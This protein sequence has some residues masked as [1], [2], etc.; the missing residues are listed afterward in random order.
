MKK[1]LQYLERKLARH[2]V[3]HVTILIALGQAAV[4]AMLMTRPQLSLRLA[5]VPDLVMVGE[6]Y[7]LFSF[8]ILPPGDGI[9]TLFGIYLFYFMGESLEAQWGTVRYNLY[10]L[11]AY[12]ATIAVAWINP[13]DPTLSTFIGGSVFLA[14]AWLFPDFQLMLF[15][16]LPV[17]IRYLALLTWL[18]FGWTMIFGQWSERLAVL[19]SVLNFLLFFGNDIF[20]RIRSN[21]RKMEQGFAQLRQRNTPLHRCTVCGVTERDDRSLEFRFCSKC[22]GA[23]EYCE[24][25]LKNHE[26]KSGSPGAKTG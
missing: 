25:H 3:P 17:K 13:G 14:F 15:F 9:L 2:A 26:H 7:R 10:L 16:V 18:V 8:V 1:L 5:L 6:W 19:A 12:L 20:W 22:D 11:I 4:W 21:K 24:I 23:Y